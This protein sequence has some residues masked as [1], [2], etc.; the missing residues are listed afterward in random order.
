M[1]E[2]LYEQDLQHTAHLPYP[3]PDG[4]WLLRQRWNNLLFAH[5][6]IPIMQM[7]ALLPASLEVDSFDGYAWAG[8]VPF[9]M[10]QV[11]SR[12]VGSRAITFPG[13]ESF[14]ELNLRTYVRSRKTG[15]RGVFF[16]ALDCSSPLSVLGART[17]FHL[18]YFP[19]EDVCGVYRRRDGVQKQAFINSLQRCD[20][21]L[22]ITLSVH[23]MAASEPGSLEEFLTEQYR[24]F[25]PVRRKAVCRQ[26]PSPGLAATAGG[27]GVPAQRSAGGAWAYLARPG[28]GVL[29]FAREL[30]VTLVGLA[31]GIGGYPD[32]ERVLWAL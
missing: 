24:L 22:L 13:T 27:G 14:E 15:L 17:L 3:L 9:V 16:F 32:R 7:Q 6:P 29:H 21:M 23:R 31:S 10:D 18:P 11:R 30:R 8:V 26:H 20:S 5:W 4:K 28:T 25:T 2:S 12:F 19:G 1:D